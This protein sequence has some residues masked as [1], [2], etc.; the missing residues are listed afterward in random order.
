MV[1]ATLLGVILIPV[2]YVI[3]QSSRERLKNLL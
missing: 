2:L 3:V 1:A